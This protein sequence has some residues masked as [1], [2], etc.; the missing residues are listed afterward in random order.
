MTEPQ[1]RLPISAERGKRSTVDIIWLTAVFGQKQKL[2]SQI[3]HRLKADFGE[4]VRRRSQLRRG[5]P[6]STERLVTR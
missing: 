6:R 1:V 5:R 4:Q 3:A 2:Q